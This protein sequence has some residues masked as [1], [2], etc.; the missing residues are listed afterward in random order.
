MIILT[1]TLSIQAKSISRPMNSGDCRGFG[2]VVVLLVV[3]V[4]V[5]LVVVDR[6]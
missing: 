5:V 4:V 2:L 1:V 3:L 6:G